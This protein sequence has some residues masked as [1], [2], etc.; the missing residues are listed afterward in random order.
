MVGGHYF[1]SVGNNPPTRQKRASSE[2]RKTR[3]CIRVPDMG[4]PERTSVDTAT[5]HFSSFWFECRSPR[6]FQEISQKTST[7]K[8]ISIPTPHSYAE[9]A[10]S[11]AHSEPHQ[12]PINYGRGKGKG[13]VKGTSQPS[14]KGKG[15]RKGQST[16][17]YIDE[18]GWAQI[19]KRIHKT[20][21]TRPKTFFFDKDGDFHFNTAPGYYAISRKLLENLNSQQTMKLSWKT[22]PPQVKRN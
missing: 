2:T 19:P 3:F 6:H 21:G 5:K 9:A 22:F 15:G 20:A 13:S 17:V 1:Y 7:V 4:N 16:E 8:L 10:R 18:Q 12:P 11:A 14:G